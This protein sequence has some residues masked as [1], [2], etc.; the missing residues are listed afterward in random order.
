VAYIDVLIARPIGTVDRR[1]FG[2][3]AEHLGR[4]VQG[5]LI[6]EEP[7]A[8]FRADVLAA[9]RD[10]GVTNVRWP[11]DA[12]PGG[13]E[14]GRFGTGDFLA[15]CAVAAVEPVLGLNMDTGTLDEALAWVE[16]WC[17]TR[18]CCC[19]WR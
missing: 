16:Y 11:L 7:P 8:G 4:C 5:G 15:W 19:G 18:R 12:A 6:T 3:V 1:I 14:P 9:V 10:L 13:E 17:A 2:G